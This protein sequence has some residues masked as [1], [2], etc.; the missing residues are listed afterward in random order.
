MVFRLFLIF[1]LVPVAELYVLIKIGQLIGPLP[2]VGFLLLSALVGTWLARHQGFAVLR[3][4]QEELAQGRLPAAQLLDGAMVL[5]G[6]VFLVLPGFLTDIIG[7]FLLI[8]VTRALFKRLLGLW[9]QKK[10]A[11]GQFVV[12]RRC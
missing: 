3:R 7:L 12:V 9:L 8:P 1:I 10:L 5:A 2:T 4:I 11:R 6:G